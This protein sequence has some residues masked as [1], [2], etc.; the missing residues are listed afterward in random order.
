MICKLK[1]ESVHQNYYKHMVMHVPHIAQNAVMK[2][3]LI[4]GS[5]IFKNL[6]LW[7]VKVVVHW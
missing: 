4:N 5:K 7:I 1:Q 6:C 2:P 3:Q